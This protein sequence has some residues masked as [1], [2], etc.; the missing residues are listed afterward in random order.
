MGAFRRAAGSGVLAAILAM[1]SVAFAA[2]PDNVAVDFSKGDAHALYAKFNN[3]AWGLLFFFWVIGLL[4][5]VFTAGEGGPK[6]WPVTRRGIYV[7][8]AL[9]A[10]PMI[11]GTILVSMDSLAKRIMPGN[12]FGKWY[13][14]QQR[15]QSSAIVDPTGT[16][17]KPPGGATAQGDYPT[18]ARPWP[19]TKT[20]T[21]PAGLVSVDAEFI[22]PNAPPPSAS[23]LSLS[24]GIWVPPTVPG[25][26]CITQAAKEHDEA[27]IVSGIK[28]GLLGIVLA[29]IFA[30]IT[31]AKFIVDHVGAI[32][33]SVF[34]VIGP[35]AISAGALRLTGT[36]SAWFKAFIGYASWPVFTS[37]LMALVVEVTSIPYASGEGYA[38]ALWIG[39]AV[40]FSMMS[41]PALASQVIGA[42]GA[43]FMSGAM[44]AFAGAA[45]GEAVAAKGHVA[46]AAG[47]VLPGVAGEAAKHLIAG[48]TGVGAAALV[49]K[50]AV[51]AVA[52]GAGSMVSN[53][54]AGGAGGGSSAAGGAGGGSSGA[55]GGGSVASLPPGGAT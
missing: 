15:L 14:N 25:W 39:L 10:Y 49:A 34:Y 41:A 27:Y 24:E 46:G 35:L 12:M 55:D 36:I 33:A 23:E 40:M 48:G 45:A 1:P 21:C 50:A 44:G 11:A 53:D 30:V 22:D 32:L 52:S 26:K 2:L 29:I 54:P 3:V 18:A 13:A 6:I 43:G 31:G 37:L 17:S 7:A 51:K 42:A 5:E 47:A 19:K 16:L 4:V 20:G 38:D 8:A 9:L 28:D